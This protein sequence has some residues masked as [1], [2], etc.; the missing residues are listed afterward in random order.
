MNSY[1]S[2]MAHGINILLL[3]KTT[4]EKASIGNLLLKS[5]VFSKSAS[6]KFSL[7]NH[8]GKAA[9]YKKLIHVTNLAGLFDS[10][11][12]A[13]VNRRVVAHVM[14]INGGFDAIVIVFRY[15]HNNNV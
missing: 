4:P 7:S 10:Y 8:V 9:A 6:R 15:I 1:R 14:K 13:N 11:D 3:G 2:G 12:T 5:N